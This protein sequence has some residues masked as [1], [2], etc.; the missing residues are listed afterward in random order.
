MLVDGEVEKMLSELK[1]MVTSSGGEYNKYLESIKKTEDDMKKDFRKRAVKRVKFGLILR[2]IAKAEK[3]EANEDELKQER[4]K[5]LAKYQ[6][7]EKAME[8]IQSPQYEDYMRNLIQNR[9]VFEY[10]TKTMVK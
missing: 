1:T 7:D 4:E 3:I 8:Q 9:K 5:T 10:L 2:E 6:H